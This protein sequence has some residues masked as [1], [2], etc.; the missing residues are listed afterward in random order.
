MKERR[1]EDRIDREMGVLRRKFSST[2][3]INRYRNRS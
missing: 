2:Q 1:R 3:A